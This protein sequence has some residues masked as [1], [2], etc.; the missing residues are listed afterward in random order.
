MIWKKT[1]ILLMLCPSLAYAGFLDSVIDQTKKLAEETVNKTVETVTGNEKQPAGTEAGNSSQATVKSS[2]Q[3]ISISDIPTTRRPSTY[4]T[5]SLAGLRYDQSWLTE[6][7]LLKSTQASISC[8][9]YFRKHNQIRGTGCMGEFIRNTHT[10]HLIKL[11]PLFSDSEIDGRNPK[12]AAQEYK[13]RM[14]P[15]LLKLAQHLPPEFGDT[16][17]WRGSYDFD[18]GV[19]NLSMTGYDQL[20]RSVQNRLP[21]EALHLDLRNPRRPNFDGTAGEYHKLNVALPYIGGITALAFDRDLSQGRV[22]M[23]AA[24][25]EKLFQGLNKNQI[26]SGT[27]VVEFRV[28]GTAGEAALATVERVLLLSTGAQTF[29]LETVKPFMTLPAS[30]F[31]KLDAPKPKSEAKAKKVTVAAAAA[32]PAQA[33]PEPAAIKEKTG[34]HHRAQTGSPY[35]PDLV[36]LQLGMTLEQ[37]DG[38]IRA[39][40]KP[41]DVVKG[42]PQ[43]PFVQARGYLLEPGDEAITVLT[44]NSPAGER[45]AGYVRYVHFDPANPPTQ[46][47]IASSLEKKYGAPTYAYDVKGMFDRHW[48]STSQGKP[49]TEQ[50]QKPDKC[51]KAA[52]LDS[53]ANTFS[54]DQ[55]RPYLWHLPWL[56]ERP[57]GTFWSMKPGD[58]DRFK[59]LNE[60]GPALVGKYSDNSGQLTGPTL[61]LALFDGPWIIDA[62]ASYNQSQKEQGAKGLSL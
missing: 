5:L 26:T 46:I 30:A 16:V 13:D 6:D 43:S 3:D 35:G 22:A 8:Q 4:Q 23:S 52:R 49:I 27:A 11:A 2:D 61:S 51:E 34:A 42:S 50:S 45:V 9:Q 14:K 57:A 17:R 53:G 29:D 54:N 18:Q 1:L 37:A 33:K 59:N 25:A 47:A 38:V 48:L 7:N 56:P 40:K 58:P 24:E 55:G 19:L 12:F 28:D 60:C 31:P 41:R 10:G 39:Y 15:A 36:G 62:M 20:Q 44:L 21:K 32:K